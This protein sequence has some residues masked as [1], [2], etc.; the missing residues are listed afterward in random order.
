M[1][2]RHH[3]CLHC[4]TEEP[5]SCEEGLVERIAELQRANEELQKLLKESWLRGFAAAVETVQLSMSAAIKKVQDKMDS[6]A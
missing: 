5:M 2:K 4:S 3:K 1:T 6:C